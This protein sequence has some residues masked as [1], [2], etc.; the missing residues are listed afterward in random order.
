MPGLFLWA[1]DVKEPKRFGPSHIARGLVPR[2]AGDA[3]RGAS[4]RRGAPRVVCVGMAAS[5]VDTRWPPRALFTAD[6]GTRRPAAPESP[7]CFSPD[8]KRTA[9]TLR[10]PENLRTRFS[11]EAPRTYVGRH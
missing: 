5:R 3:R 11:S 6:V 7:A 8:E 9:L 1:H 4:S 2:L 10:T